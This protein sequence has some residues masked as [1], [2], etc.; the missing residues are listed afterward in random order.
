MSAQPAPAAE[1]RRSAL[2]RLRR[3]RAAKVVRSIAKARAERE[4]ADRFGE[5]TKR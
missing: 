3:Q 2:V 1:P 4:M 5:E